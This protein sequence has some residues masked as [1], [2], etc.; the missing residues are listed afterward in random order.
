MRERY[1][2]VILTVIALELG[3]IAINQ[4]TSP[5]QAQANASPTPVIIRG[6][7]ISGAPP[8]LLPV[9]VAGQLRQVPAAVATQLQRV[10]VQVP[11]PVNMRAI[12]PVKIESDRPI[13][14]EAGRAP[15]KVEIT[16]YTPA[17]KPG[18]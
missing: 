15:L 3:W 4:S 1:L 2:K 11:D 17:Q 14:I 7:N 9:A 12:A 5:V 13:Q 10:E 16:P 6:I 18:E 8:E